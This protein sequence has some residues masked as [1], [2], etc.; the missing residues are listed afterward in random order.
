ME[1]TVFLVNQRASIL[2]LSAVTDVSGRSVVLQPKGS[3]G[4]RRECF[5]DAADHP[6]VQTM[7][8]VR[9]VRVER[10]QAQEPAAIA[11]ATAAPPPAEPLT[12]PRESRSTS[13]AAAPPDGAMDPAAA[14]PLHDSADAPGEPRRAKKR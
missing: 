10:R 1:D 7:L 11:P 3:P 8:D 9:W 14:E 13:T 2:D 12:D 4:A 6:H 5:A